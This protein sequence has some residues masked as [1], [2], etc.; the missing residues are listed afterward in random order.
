MRTCRNRVCMLILHRAARSSRASNSV[1]AVSRPAPVQLSRRTRAVVSPGP[2]TA[3]VPTVA[4]RSAVTFQAKRRCPATTTTADAA[5]G[6]GRGCPPCDQSNL[7]G[8]WR[9]MP[10]LSR[11]AMARMCRWMAS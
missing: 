8:N 6:S 7:S 1:T 5:Q 3:A 9:M 2:A 11:S 4:G 10:L